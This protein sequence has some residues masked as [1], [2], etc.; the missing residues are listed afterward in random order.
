MNEKCITINIQSL[1]GTIVIAD[2]KDLEKVEKEITSALV[3]VLK[4][5]HQDDSTAQDRAGG[6]GE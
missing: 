1:I 5:T 3:N 4:S 6:T 2:S